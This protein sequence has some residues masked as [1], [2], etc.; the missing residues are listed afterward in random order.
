MAVLIRRGRGL[1]DIFSQMPAGKVLD[2]P[3]GG[4][5]SLIIFLN[6]VMRFSHQIFFHRLSRIL[7]FRGFKQMLILFSLFEANAS[8]TFCQ[9]KALSISKIRPSSFE[10]VREF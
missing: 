6:S 4:G 5:R 8:T 10:N 3:A 9:E 7:L 2:I 1:I